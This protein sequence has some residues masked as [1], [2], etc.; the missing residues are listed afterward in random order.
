MI[1]KLLIIAIQFY[2]IL[3]QNSELK[4]VVEYNTMITKENTK[5]N[6]QL[7]YLIGIHKIKY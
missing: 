6:T 7:D 3:S 1:T 5:L 2:V 4:K